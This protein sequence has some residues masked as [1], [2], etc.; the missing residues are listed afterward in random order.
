MA[1]LCLAGALTGCANPGPPLPPSMNLP[2]V[3]TTLA[4]ERIGDT[5][6]LN[7]P[8]PHLTS[9]GLLLRRSYTVTLCRAVDA[10][11]C[12]PVQ[13]LQQNAPAIADHAPTATPHMTPRLA[14]LLTLNDPLPASLLTS[15]RR[16]LTYRVE[17]TNAA[18]RSAGASNAAM[19]ASGPEVPAVVGFHVEGAREGVRLLWSAV[20]AAMPRLHTVA[21]RTTLPAAPSASEPSAET[22]AVSQPVSAAAKP[23]NAAPKPGNA[24]ARPVNAAAKPM[25]RAPQVVFLQASARSSTTASLAT[26]DTA[27]ADTATADTD[28][29]EVATADAAAPT[30]M[31]D[32][33]ARPGTAYSYRA[34]HELTVSL[35]GAAA[36]QAFT[37]RSVWTPPASI[38]LRAIYP[39]AAPRGLLAA[40]LLDDQG[41][42][43]AVDLSWQPV[44]DT[45]I[46]GYNIYRLE[47]DGARKLNSALVTD[48]AF[49][50]RHPAPAA[51]YAVTA[52]DT[53]GNESP[54]SPAAVLAP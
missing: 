16:L 45:G 30:G 53:R 51:A 46:A 41:V 4:A 50:D 33:S 54:R 39:P 48:A 42:L 3:V 18:G 25:P 35:R 21:E 11:P 28:T 13:S 14:P 9:D 29:A 44:L 49:R 19:T 27:T 17:L 20:P 7:F 38:V 37:L 15:P 8:P 40:P 1:V 5:V 31:L 36:G 34:R 26:A 24:A 10:G 2:A 12:Q 47:R 23:G 22:T 32:A 43:I 52:V 6:S